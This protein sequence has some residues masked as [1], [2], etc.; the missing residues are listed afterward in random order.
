M[1]SLKKFIYL[2]SCSLTLLLVLVGKGY[3][4]IKTDL[5]EKI[6]YLNI[7]DFGTCCYWNKTDSVLGYEL[8]G[9]DFP[10]P[11]EKGIDNMGMRWWNA[12]DIQRFEVVCNSSA[13]A[14][15]AASMQIEYWNDN[16]PDEP[17]HMPSYED[18]EDDLWRGKWIT[19]KTNVA[20]DKNRIVFTFQPLTKDEI[21]NAK[22]LPGKVT[23]RRTL[24]MRVK[25]P[26]EYSEKVE[27]INVFSMAAVQ[28]QSIRVEFLQVEKKTKKITGE[29]EVFNGA[30]NGL[31]GW[32]WKGGDKKTGKNAWSINT[33]AN[34]K[35]IIL[36]VLSAKA[37]LP[38]SNEETVV[39]LRT[40]N[41]T[42]SF[43]TADLSNGPV[44]VPDFSTYISWADDP[45][46]FSEDVVKGS[47]IREQILTEPE[48]SY[49]RASNEIPHKDPTEDQNGGRIFLPI[50]CDASW[51]KFAIEW[52][53]NII[54]D[55][56]R[57]KAQG[58]A[59]EICNWNID[60]LDWNFGTGEEPS[61][62]REEENSRMSILNNYL[63][64]IRADWND[65]GLLFNEE[66]FVTFPENKP[67]SPFDPNRDEFT[68]AILMVQM[69][70]SNPS[71][72]AQKAHLWLQGNQALNDITL[73]DGYVFDQ[74]DG[75]KYI[76]C[77]TKKSNENAIKAETFNAGNKQGIHYEFEL[78]AGSSGTFYFCF[79]F[80]GNLTAA[81]KNIFSNL[82]YS[83]ERTRVVD[84][85]RNVVADNTVFD[86]PEEV[87]NQLSK[88]VIPHIR[89][90]VT[91]DPES[92]LYMVPAASFSYPV[93][94]NESIFQTVF[95]DRLGDF[96]TVN[97]YLE[98]FLE[99]QGSRKLPGAYTG[100]QKAVFHGVKV[101]DHNDLTALG[102]NMN[103]GTVLWGMAHHYLHSK[104]KDW[105][106]EVAPKLI[107]AADWIIEQRAQSKINDSKGNPVL[108]YGLLPAGML[109]DCP[110][111]KYWYATN[112]YSYMGMKTMAEA[113]EEAGLPQ[114]DYYKKEAEAYK[115]D[116]QTSLQKAMELAPV[117]RLRNNTYV[118]YIPTRAYQRF[119][120]FGS[121]KSKYYDRY[122]MGIY[123]TLRLSS[124]REVLYGPVTLLKTGIIDAKSPMAD[125]ILNDWEDNLTLSTS[126]N[127]NTH[128]WVDDEY[129][130]SR[131]GM[132]FQANLQ[133]PVSVYLDRQETKSAIRSLYNNFT[134]LFYP[135][136]IALSEEY[137]M[138]EHASGPF[139]KCPD[140]ARVVSQIID[141]LIEEKDDEVWLGNGIPERWLEPG[142]KVDL[143]GV[144]TR[145]G[146]YKYSLASGKEPNTIE[147]SI[148]LPENSPKT[149]FFLH[150][151]FRKEI[152][153][154]FVNGK[155]WTD[156][157]AAEKVVTLPQ[158]QNTVELL[159][160]YK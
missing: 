70:V 97:S 145:F 158:N 106:K 36:K 146:E 138:W 61:Y 20:I 80:I 53:G 31:S 8:T 135:D 24:K 59:F 83:S 30:F 18:H 155:E 19:A 112:A 51:Q 93:Y 107:M 126:M 148:S 109:E 152:Q 3:G 94:A 23:Y 124:T 122:E 82:D 90:S 143:N 43:S 108:H 129:W 35:G 42:F 67:L 26:E 10:L 72:N 100:D 89:M 79:P 154:V 14:E 47:S 45:V 28:P 86:V 116:I 127:L 16:W 58:K 52:G 144:Y 78:G 38:G 147:A 25:F 12:R 21:A 153:S 101:S 46:T 149:L 49:E 141:F 7:T 76:R 84:Y 134:S 22:Y 37:L 2:F 41:G 5:P 17:P 48:H 130:F 123:P 99:L 113:F 56:D 73:E 120:Y 119:R 77:Y 137:R 102:Y 88:S 75:T 4:E 98:T 34:G 27:D 96:K 103:H 63:P 91:K 151:P 33:A 156:W 114:A 117:V 85:W 6:E 121:K 87:F 104:D 40:S 92:G 157:N 69:K 44:Y 160:K 142:L 105:L 13:T 32:N 66:A 111:W 133:N 54:I 71:L 81:E 1:L 55:R 128:G 136:V 50:A 132:V 140:E 39:T 139:Y 74:K 68:P 62:G 95:M 118:P 159:V 29:V 15:I 125:W 65:K 115:K 57:T 60:E 110:E 64:V 11:K 9:N 150:D 131:G